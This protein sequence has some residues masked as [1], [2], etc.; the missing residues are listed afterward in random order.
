MTPPATTLAVVNLGIG[1]TGKISYSLSFAAT[2]DEEGAGVK[3]HTVYVSLDRGVWEVWKRRTTL[4]ELIYEAP[5]GSTAEFIVLSA[6]NAGNVESAG[7]EATLPPY[8]PGINLG[9][10]PTASQLTPETRRAVVPVSPTP[11]TN[12]LFIEALKQIP[13]TLD[14]RERPRPSRRS[15]SPSRPRPMP[16]ASRSPAR[17]SAAIGIAF[18]PD[19]ASLFVS[20]GPGRNCLYKVGVSGSVTGPLTTLDVPIYGMAFDPAGRL[21]ATTGGGPLVRLDPETGAILQRYGEGVEL[22]MAVHP[23]SGKL[24]LATAAGIEIFDPGDRDLRPLLVHPGGG[25]GLLPGRDALRHLL[26]RGRLPAPVRQPRQRRDRPDHGGSGRGDRLRDERDPDGEP[27]APDPRRSRLRDD[28]GHGHPPDRQG[29]PGRASG[30]IP[31]LSPD[32][33]IFV[34]QGGEVDLLA[35]VTAPVVLAVRRS[36]GWNCCRW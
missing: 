20:G 25:V 15:T 1:Q 29:R 14:L 4:T 31:A 28:D 6:D 17:A 24:Y 21:W 16:G 34:A 9:T 32:G 18:S 5:A 27:A 35:P 7:S 11:S 26:A 22:G 8:N 19:G 2:D 3:D 36:T 13:G 33:R 23:T 10:A 12:P 30:R